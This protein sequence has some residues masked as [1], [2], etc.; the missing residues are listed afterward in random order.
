MMSDK[1]VIKKISSIGK[2]QRER[3]LKFGKSLGWDFTEGWLL[4]WDYDEKLFLTL[5]DLCRNLPKLY[6]HHNKAV[7]G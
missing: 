1:Y 6:P 7:G 4:E 2:T 3:L 5:K